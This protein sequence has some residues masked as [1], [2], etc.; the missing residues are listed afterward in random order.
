M[1][2]STPHMQ[3][4]GIVDMVLP[5]IHRPQRSWALQSVATGP[6]GFTIRR[7]WAPGL[8]DTRWSLA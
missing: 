5:V 2:G 6:L 3:C 4:L 1:W 7:H 8:D